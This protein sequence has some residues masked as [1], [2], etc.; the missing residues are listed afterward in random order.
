[1]AITSYGYDGSIGESIWARMAPRVSTPYWVLDP[2]H[3]KLSINTSRDR[4]IDIAPGEFGGSGVFDVSDAI[5]T[6]TFEP[7][8]SGWRYDLIVARRNWQGVGGKTTFEVIK[9]GSRRIIPSF[10]R[11]P[12]VMD[13]QLLALVPLQAGRVRPD[14]II[15]LRGF[16][17]NGN[18]I[19]RDALAMEGYSNWPGLQVQVGREVYTCQTDRTWVRT[20]LISATSPAY[21]FRLRRK[22]TLKEGVGWQGLGSG[23]STGND[24]T[25][26]IKV[27]HDG[28]IEF[29]K[30]GQYT[31]NG[32]M[33]A[34]AKLDNEPGSMK[35]RMDGLWVQPD[36]E[37]HKNE[38]PRGVNSMFSWHGTVNAGDK[39][40]FL[41]AHYNRRG[42]QMTF[43]FEINIEMVN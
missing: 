43:E 6:V 35:F 40:N 5:E 10:N 34:D 20:G 7:V 36:F 39:V 32:N 25:M 23:W 30:S 3:L 22:K 38:Y 41:A 19:V 15:D 1:M 14:G 27:L 28:R 29:T 2:D 9:G 12:G 26:G 31:I 4:A 11:N 18:V 13:D 24:N 8:S 33:W 37:V 16:G 17:V 42:R 21:R